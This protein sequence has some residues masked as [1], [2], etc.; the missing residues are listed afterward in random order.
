M[1]GSGLVTNGSL[2][3]TGTVWPGYPDKGTLTVTDGTLTPAKLAFELDDNGTCGRLEVGGTLDLSGA[4]IVVD[5]ALAATGKGVVTLAT[6]SSIT[7][8]PI[9]NQ[10]DVVLVTKSNAVRIYVG[11]IGTILSIR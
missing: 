7:G 1:M 8:T 5:N 11:R 4:E 6:A 2:T 9:F 10:S 3:V